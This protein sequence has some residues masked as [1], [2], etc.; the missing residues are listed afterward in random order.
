MDKLSLRFSKSK[1]GIIFNRFDLDQNDFGFLKFD[2]VP[3]IMFYPKGIH[4][5][6][7]EVKVFYKNQDTLPE[8]VIYK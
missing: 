8:N 3:L 1:D 7:V 2:K 5:K 6:G 4:A